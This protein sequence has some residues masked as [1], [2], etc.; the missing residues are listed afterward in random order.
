MK[1]EPRL[2]LINQVASAV[3]CAPI[4]KAAGRLARAGRAPQSGAF[5]ALP[6]HLPP[7]P[8]R[9]APTGRAGARQMRPTRANNAM[10]SLTE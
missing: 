5:A 4:G 9:S 8:I 3:G 7:P 6:L 2:G 1:S 10:S